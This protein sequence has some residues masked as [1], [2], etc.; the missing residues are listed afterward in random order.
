MTKNKQYYSDRI[1]DGK[2]RRIIVDENG[3]MIN[4]NPTKDGLKCLELSQAKRGKRCC[5]CGSADTYIGPNL[6][7]QWS[8][9]VCDKKNCTRYICH[10][11]WHIYYNNLPDSVLNANSKWRNGM[12]DSSST[13]GKGFIGQQIVAKAYGVEDCNLKMK[14]FRF[15]VDLSKMSKYGYIEVKTA[16]LNKINDNWGFNTRRDQKYNTLILVCMDHN[17]PWKD[18]MMAYAIPYEEA[19]KRR[20]I[21]I[22]RHP[23]RYT[24]YKD[25]EI[26]C[27]LF[28]DAYHNMKLE[29]CK[30]LRRK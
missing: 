3:D 14:N 24:W 10:N 30:I 27:K 5:A 2:I 1:I 7:P 22:V 17:E 13:N 21:T 11:C 20:Q 19:I 12:L 29:N 18:V 8:K 28:N 4:R 9:H 6:N 26:D 23:T 25:F 15:C 16:T